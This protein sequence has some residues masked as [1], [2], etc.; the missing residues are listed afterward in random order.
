MLH[1]I[2]A[3]VDGFAWLLR[4]GVE[5]A[6]GMGDV[7]VEACAGAIYGLHYTHIRRFGPARL[8]EIVP[9]CTFS[10]RRPRSRPTP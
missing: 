10:G 2:D 9:A 6:P 7:A 3:A 1:R 8:P 5:Q 4:P